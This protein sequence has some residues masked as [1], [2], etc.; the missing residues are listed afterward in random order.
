MSTATLLSLIA[1]LMLVAWAATMPAMAFA[2]PTVI[3]VNT[4]RIRTGREPLSGSRCWTLFAAYW[5]LTLIV[6]AWLLCANR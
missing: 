5:L 3:M 1:P 6:A 2:I 4:R